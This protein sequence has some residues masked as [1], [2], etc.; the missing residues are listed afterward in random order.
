MPPFVTASKPPL[1]G[2]TSDRY[3]TMGACA[4]CAAPNATTPNPFPVSRSTAP[5]APTAHAAG[6]SEVCVAIAACCGR[7]MLLLVVADTVHTLLPP[8]FV[9][10]VAFRPTAYWAYP[11]LS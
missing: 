1:I 8:P 11:S 5:A 6:T 10:I 7:T 9:R 3:S 2:A 4:A